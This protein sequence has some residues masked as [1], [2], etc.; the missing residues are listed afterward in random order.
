MK[1]IPMKKCLCEREDKKNEEMHLRSHISAWQAKTEGLF[2]S[3]L[4]FTC[5]R[6]IGE[7]LVRTNCSIPQWT[8]QRLSMRK[9]IQQTSNLQEQ[10]NDDD[11]AA[12]VDI[13]PPVL[14][15]AD[16][17]CCTHTDPSCFNIGR[18]KRQRS[19]NIA[20]MMMTTIIT[21]I[22][23][24]AIFTL[25]PLLRNKIMNSDEIKAPM[26]DPH[27]LPCLASCEV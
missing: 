13:K 21:I 25:T 26:A 17:D 23:I 24:I 27:P 1:V 9:R 14:Q 12:D 8:T 3:P 2:L 20:Q 19:Q 18:R 7:V 16:P 15:L 4:I 5:W 10:L 6:L 11:A 22:T